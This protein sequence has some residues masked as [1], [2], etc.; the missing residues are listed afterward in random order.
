MDGVT[1]LEDY[2]FLEVRA[3]SRRKAIALLQELKRVEEE[4]LRTGELKKVN[5]L[6]GYAMTKY[7]Q[8]Y[9]EEL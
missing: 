7:P 2:D 9:K 3:A 1:K 8:R 6:N 4:K 5:I